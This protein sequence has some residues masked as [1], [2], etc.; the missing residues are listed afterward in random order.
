MINDDKPIEYRKDFMKIKFASGD[1][2]SLGKAVNIL[3]M[4]V[5]A[6]S[7]LERNDKYYSQIFFH[8]CAYKL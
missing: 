2:L 1:V 3:D 6:A 7:V 8:E 4:I 5:I